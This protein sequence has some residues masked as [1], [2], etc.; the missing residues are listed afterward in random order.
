MTFL[1]NGKQSL[2]APRRVLTAQ[3]NDRLHHMRGCLTG[4]MGLARALLQA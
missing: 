3:L 1:E 2:G 4:A